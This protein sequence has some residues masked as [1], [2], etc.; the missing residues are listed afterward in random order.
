MFRNSFHSK[1]LNIE[2]A[3]KLKLRQKWKD[4]FKIESSIGFEITK[5][6]K[7]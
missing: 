2:E 7:Q 1:P 3:I 4:Q 6:G 5:E